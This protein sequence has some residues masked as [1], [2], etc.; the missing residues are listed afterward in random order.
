MHGRLSHESFGV[1]GPVTRNG[2]LV[3]EAADPIVYRWEPMQ[4][5]YDRLLP[6]VTIGTTAPDWTEAG[7]DYL[8]L[9][10]DRLDVER[11]ADVA[12]RLVRD[13]DDVRSRVESSRIGKRSVR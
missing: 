5:Y 7:N 6:W 1:D 4:P 11:V 8:Q 2:S 12:G 13:V 9:I 10:N 3:W